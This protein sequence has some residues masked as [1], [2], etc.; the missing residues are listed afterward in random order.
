MMLPETIMSR[1][2]SPKNKVP[3]WALELK[4]RRTRL[5]LT[6]EELL[7]RIGDVMSQAYLSDIERGKVELQN[8]S[9]N[10]I[11]ALARA[12]EWTLYDL[13][14][15][16]GVDIGIGKPESNVTI[17]PDDQVVIMCPAYPLSDAGR[18]DL[19]ERTAALVNVP[20]KEYFKGL[21][22]FLELT[23]P[24]SSTTLH[25]IDTRD[26]SL[27]A[28][29]HYLLISQNTPSIAEFRPFGSQGVFV[30]Q[31]QLLSP[32]AV[33]VLGRRLQA[34]IKSPSTPAN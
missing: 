33:Q 18:P 6:Q 26:K 21:Q 29:Q 30:L 13:Q 34:V 15:T 2:P 8:I 4:A 24:A 32:D 16:T 7:G 5:G 11:T 25:Y 31:N 12:L 20:K 14:E 9:I 23:P 19:L 27:V 1:G 3:S 17:I 22:I 10:K 28:G